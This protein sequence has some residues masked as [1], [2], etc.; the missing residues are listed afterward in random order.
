MSKELLC[1]HPG[2]VALH[3]TK[4]AITRELY[5]WL[6]HGEAGPVI[7]RD[8]R[9]SLGEDLVGLFVN[10]FAFSGVV[11][12]QSGIYQ[13][14]ERIVFPMLVVEVRF[15]VEEQVVPVVGI[16]VVRTPAADIHVEWPLIARLLPSIESL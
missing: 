15:G 8:K 2:E 9:R 3:A 5:V 7:D 13:L 4:H 14:V 16:L 6:G 12:E 10:C 1:R 11:F